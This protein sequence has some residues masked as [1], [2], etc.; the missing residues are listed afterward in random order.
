M[1][2]TTRC[3]SIVLA[4][5]IDFNLFGSYKWIVHQGYLSRSTSYLKNGLKI[6]QRIYFHKLVFSF[7][8]SE[9]TGI[10]DHINRNRLDC[11][12]VNLRKISSLGNSQNSTRRKDCK[13]KYKGVIK[14]SEGFVSKIKVNGKSIQLGTF[15]TDFEA[16]IAYNRAAL[17]YHLSFASINDIEDDGF[18]LLDV[19]DKRRSI[20]N[21]FYGV[22]PSGGKFR[23]RVT[24]KGEKIDLGTYESSI[25][26]AK[27]YDKYLIENKLLGGHYRLNFIS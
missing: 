4:D 26:A 16:A 27:T 25:E 12:R 5:D 14:K 1:E 6:N 19:R 9:Y 17:K 3:N 10:V 13:S 11:R 24:V 18:L 15:E 20:E 21:R 8:D 23:T 22:Y 7:I 2:Y